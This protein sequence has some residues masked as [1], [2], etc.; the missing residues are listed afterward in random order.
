MNRISKNTGCL[1]ACLLILVPCRL[2]GQDS[3]PAVAKD[4]IYA[5]SRVA[6]ET[7]IKLRW[8]PSN[9]KAW[10]DGKK[11]GYTVERYTM[12]I[13]KVWQDS[14]V[15]LVVD[16]K[17]TPLPLVEWEQAIHESDYA[18][19]IA[20]AF[21]GEEFSL[22]SVSGDIGSII[23]QAN[24]LEQ[25]F[26]TSV[27]MAE[28]DYKAAEMAG[29]AWTDT[30]AKPNE[31]YLYRIY[32]NRPGNEEGDTAV[33]YTGFDEMRP[34][35]APIGLTAVFGDK[36]VMLSWNYALLAS[37]YHSYHVE[38]MAE[39]ETV[40]HRIT[41]IPVST[42]T[43]GMAEIMYIDSLPDNERNYL[44]RIHGLTGFDETGPPS[45]TIRGKGKEPA[46]C[47]PYIINGAFTG[48][49]T[50][51]VYWEFDC[52]RIELVE[53]LQLWRSQYPEKDFDL[54]MDNI[55]VEARE[56]SFI[57][58]D[59]LNYIKL[60]AINKDSTQ[61]ESFPFLLRQTDSIP[62]AVPTGLK[63]TIDTLCVAHLEW[64][65]NQEPDLRGY[66]I[67][68]GFTETEEK[69]SILS[70]FLPVNE[71]ADTLSLDLANA[72]VY[73][74][75]TAADIRYN[76]SQRSQSV[77][78]AKPNRITPDE[79]VFT[80]Y[81]M[82]GG[83]VKLSWLTSPGQADVKYILMRR[84]SGQEGEGDVI[85][86]GDHTR[87]AYT[88][89]PEESGS[90]AYWVVA[91]G[92]GGKQSKSPQALVLYISVEE[93][94]NAV[95]GFRSYADR[96][97]NYIELSWRKHERAQK[98]RIY[99]A[100]EGSPMSLWKETEAATN[101]IADEHVSPDTQYS[102]TILFVSPQGRVSKSKTI[103]VHY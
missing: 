6:D 73:Y 82:E 66:R 78:A 93:D 59:E 70:D 36:S 8:A 92:A 7:T 54:V 91:T 28:Y 13:D 5:R 42:L 1:L 31:K 98:Y 15:K 77:S 69:S 11:Y 97:R 26:A 9:T 74:A 101:R 23:N 12:M 65:A 58:R 53:K 2:A 46:S 61:R 44:Y 56:E 39:G 41:E 88:D 32:L 86:T 100:E 72:R 51:A 33:V 102:Y 10:V 52:P 103:V 29:W 4:N 19:V 75:L 83:K 96:K 3:I 85:F 90:Y 94:L 37:T 49:D 34:L 80:G 24:E 95:S 35:P 64:D 47:I 67:L 25:R 21:Y 71:Y 22:T 38:R 17:F 87:N 89:E 40:F 62:P 16:R 57:L 50:V 14:P 68:R 20:Q 63:V 81:E 43:E 60:I 76:E 99:K 84:A 45:D 79:P 27:F 30:L 48:K 18:A 55:P